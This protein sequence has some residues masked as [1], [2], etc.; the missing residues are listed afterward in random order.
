MPKDEQ[1][2][3]T[4]SDYI[5]RIEEAEQTVHLPHDVIT[6]EELNIPALVSGPVERRQIA[7]RLY[8]QPMCYIVE[9][10]PDTHIPEHSHDEDV[11]RLMIK[12]C[13]TLTTGDKVREFGVGTWF[14]VRANVRYKIDTKTGYTAFS[15]YRHLCM[16]PHSR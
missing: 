4:F 3:D 5:R 9:V 8:E 2:I 11:F 13:L 7:W 1:I 14:V 10:K 12:G 16:N 15:G 6:S